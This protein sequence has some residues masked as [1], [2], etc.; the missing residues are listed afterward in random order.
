VSSTVTLAVENFAHLSEVSV[1]L[2][3]LTVLVGAQGTGK[4]LAL[5]WFKTAMDGK[6][7]VAALRDAGQ[8]V[9]QP[10]K[11]VDLIF[12]VGMGGAWRKSTTIKLDGHALSPASIKRRG[13]GKERSSSSPRIGRCS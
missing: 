9:D 4:S 1:E 6:Q 12:G 3:D 7:I 2:G 5:Q 13:S 10:D 8:N 11:L